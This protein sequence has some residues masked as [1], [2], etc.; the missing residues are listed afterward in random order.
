MH[1]KY[2][3]LLVIVFITF[4]TAAAKGNFYFYVEGGNTS[5]GSECIK[6][7]HYIEKDITDAENI[8]LTLTAKCGERLFVMTR[9]NFGKRMTLS[10]KGN[11]LTTAVIVSTLRTSLMFPSKDIPRV[12]LMQILNDYKAARY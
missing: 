1:I 10:Y 5:F 7:I 6:S 4:T 2:G 8:S 12:L 11:T 9:Q 3:L